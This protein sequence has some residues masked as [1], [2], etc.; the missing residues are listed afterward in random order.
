M[1]AC[2]FTLHA[3]ERKV[4]WQLT[5]RCN[6]QCSY[7]IFAS[8]PRRDKE[9]LTQQEVLRVIDQIADLGFKH[10]KFTGGEPLVRKDLWRILQRAKDRNLGFD[11]STN[12]SLLTRPQA[13]LLSSIAPKFVHVSLDG[14]DRYEHEYVRGSGSF[15]PTIDGIKLLGQLDVKLRIGSVI[16]RQNQNS[17]L[18]QI[19]NAVSLK[20]QTIIFS[21]MEPAGRLK[22][23]YSQS[24]T[25]SIEDLNL[26]LTDLHAR[27]KRWIEVKSNFSSANHDNHLTHCPAAKDFIF[28]DAHG[29]VSGCSWISEKYPEAL[30]AQT[31]KTFSLNSLI[32]FAHS[33]LVQFQSRQLSSQICPIGTNIAKQGGSNALA[34]LG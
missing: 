14:S 28:I 5:N 24:T 11:I 10:I 34:I 1:S 23:D 26:E 27:F 2:K 7:C 18:K 3:G 17:L 33:H 4:L 19:I 22:G 13:S 29:R 25:R 12:A 21:I 8:G 16:H 32:Q 6:Y 15:K 30:S 9:E 31:L 20:A